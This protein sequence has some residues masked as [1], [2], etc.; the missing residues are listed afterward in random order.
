MSVS[1]SLLGASIDRVITYGDPTGGLPSERNR[2]PVFA[3]PATLS[4]RVAEICLNLLVDIVKQW[5][6]V[7]VYKEKPIPFNDEIKNR[8]LG[9]V[10]ANNVKIFYLE[11]LPISGTIRA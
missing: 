6:S 2:R 7:A 1:A 4:R 11:L 10:C 8:V 9:L 3:R 5:N